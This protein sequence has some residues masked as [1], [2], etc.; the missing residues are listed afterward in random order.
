MSYSHLP[1]SHLAG[2]PGGAA[3][4]PAEAARFAVPAHNAHPAPGVAPPDP[5]HDCPGHKG[6]G[7]L[8]RRSSIILTNRNRRGDRGA[9]GPPARAARLSRTL[10]FSMRREDRTNSEGRL[11]PGVAPPDPAHDCPG[12]VGTRRAEHRSME[13]DGRACRRGLPIPAPIADLWGG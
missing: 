12:H 7:V 1:Q 13:H 5:A 10:T 9:A 6:T 8:E 2:V 11:C 4:P 3:S